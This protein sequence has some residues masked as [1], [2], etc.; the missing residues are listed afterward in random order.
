VL[1]GEKE[2][3]SAWVRN[4][5]RDSEIRHS[6]W[7]NGGGG[8]QGVSSECFGVGG[9]ARGQKGSKGEKHGDDW[10][11]IKPQTGREER[12]RLVQWWQRGGRSGERGSRWRTRKR[13]PPTGDQER[14]GCAGCEIGEGRETPTCGSRSHSAGF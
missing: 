13:G 12:G 3:G 8:F 5:L 4:R 11:L 1:I 6:R 7:P 9:G 2:D 10:R 14:C